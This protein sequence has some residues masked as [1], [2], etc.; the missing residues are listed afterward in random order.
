M[1]SVTISSA[2]RGSINKEKIHSQAPLLLPLQRPH[3]NSLSSNLGEEKERR[4]RERREVAAVL[5]P[6]QKKV[7]LN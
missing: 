1:I 5:M 6:D 7:F 4:K 2:R 3:H